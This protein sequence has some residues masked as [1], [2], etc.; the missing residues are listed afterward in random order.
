MVRFF[1][2]IHDNVNFF[3]ARYLQ[4]FSNS[5]DKRNMCVS[6]RFRVREKPAKYFLLSVYE[7]YGPGPRFFI[8]RKT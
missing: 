8:I 1:S 6:L 5:L 2:H 4:I 3:S 7:S